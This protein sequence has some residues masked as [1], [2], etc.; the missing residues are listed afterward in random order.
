M[1]KPTSIFAI[2]CTFLAFELYAQPSALDISF[3]IDGKTNTNIET[4]YDGA[5]SV[6]IQP[7]GKIV[8]AGY[9]F[10]GTNED[11]AL[12]RFNTDG[13]LDN[14]FSSGGK[15]T[16]D[17][18]M[19]N[20]RAYSIAL[21]SD[22][23]I[24]VAG[25]S[26]N[27]SNNDFAVARYNPNGNLDNSF[28]LDGKLTSTIGTGDDRALSLAL[29]PDGKIVVGGYST[30]GANYDFALVRYNPNGSLDIN[31]GNA[32]IITTAIG[33]D[34]DYANAIAL[35]PDGKILA[36][37]RSFNGSNYDFALVRY[38]SDGTMDNSFG[39]S[40]IV[41]T[42]IGTSSDEA[43]CIALQPDG[44][45]ILGGYS[46]NVVTGDFALARYNS[47]GAL[48][49]S[50]DVDGK[51]TTAFGSGSS[52]ERGSSV[53]LQ[54]DGKIILIG[55]PGD[56]L[57]A[58][59]N[60]DG[61][62]DNTFSTD[63]KQNTDFDSG[64]DKGYSAALQSDGKIVV[65]GHSYNSADD[66]FALARYNIDGNLDIS[67]DLDGEV[68]LNF[69][70]SRERINS[71]AIQP[72]GKIVAAG[73][74]FNG[75]NQYFAVARYNQDGNLDD[76]FDSDGKLTTAFGSS[77]N[78][79]AQTVLLQS[80]GKIVVVG[81]TRYG[82]KIE[83]ALARYNTNGTLDNSFGISGKATTYFGNYPGATAASAV[84]QP[85]DDK[86]IV[87][88]KTYNA[89]NDAD[90]ALARFNSNGTLDYSFGVN[91]K[92]TTTVG[93]GNDFPTGIVV[94]SDGKIV[95][96]GY[97]ASGSSHDFVV[98]RYNTNGS[99]DNT[100]SNDGKLT[101]P[102]G[103]SDD[104]A[105][106]VALQTD[107][108]IVV[109]GDSWNGTDYD[110]ALVRYNADGTLD[111]SFDGDGKLTTAI[112]TYYDDYQSVAIQSNGKI[113]VAGY[114]YNSSNRDFV[115]VR[116]N[117]DG[118]LDNSFDMDGIVTTDFGT[119]GDGATSI[120]IQ[121]DGRIV[122]GGYSDV[123]SNSDFALARYLT[124]ASNSTTDFST[125]INSV[126][127]YPNPMQQNTLLKYNLVHQEKISIYLLDMQGKQVTTVIEYQNQE[128]GEHQQ[129]I[130]LP[131]T[132]P[133]NFYFIILSSASGSVYKKVARQCPK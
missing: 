108:K 98:V 13:S 33:S 51:L 55:Y 9:S 122:A 40:G 110:F 18:S 48:D 76:N 14:N 128:A 67:F 113:V 95:V 34:N 57:L 17:F 85:A 130:V 39:S 106:S 94:Q 124:D 105:W 28:S 59:Y 125:N 42:E 97:S 24:L 82:D 65:V 10:N 80:S 53:I 61:V 29:Q 112:N 100:F 84:I 70:V 79:W 36:A 11:F 44:K 89:S 86:I 109:A 6:A 81:F 20:D 52:D 75:S 120:A 21:Q 74:T 45:I 31:F 27:G 93:T 32:G 92:V 111:N 2:L 37:G 54:P 131:E 4:G 16:T 127:I 68:T 56:F 77:R 62:L 63:G 103:A 117:S 64:N 25:Y 114:T 7:D 43:T 115:L 96:S 46:L 133:S 90:F 123:N 66:D 1:K 23:K 3:G 60:P 12:A 58:R 49:T 102:I 22:G 88:G 129:P 8:T 119:N 83:F 19:K 99:L 101:T 50:F 118:T 30:N 132:L 73:V 116:Y 26:N 5:N 91:G 121:S 72:D 78:D 107:G 87:V 38:N 104:K 15:Q 126:L 69:G 71:I 41:T 47:D 35:Q